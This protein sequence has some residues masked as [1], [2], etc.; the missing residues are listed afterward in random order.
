MFRC[1]M[2]LERGSALARERIGILGGAFDPFHQGHLRMA[3]T[4]MDFCKLDKMYVLPA[5]DDSYKT[6]AVNQE[7]RWKM[8]VTAC[9]QDSRLIPTRMEMDRIPPAYTVDTLLELK[10][11]N[12]RA[13][14]FFVLGT[15]A[16]MKLHR[17]H[18]SEEALPLCTFLVCPRAG[19]V[20]LEAFNAEKTRLTGLG[21]RFSMIRMTP[22]SISSTEIREKL[23]AGE[24]TPNL[25]SPVREYCAL[26]GLYGMPSREENA[27]I[28][29]EKLFQ[30]LTAHRFAHSLSVAN[31]ARRLARIYGIDQRQAEQAGLLH[32]CAKCMPLKKMRRIA[33]EHSLTNDPAVLNSNALMHSLV[34]AWVARNEYDMADPEVLEAIAYHNTGHVGMS[35]LAMCVCLADSIEPTRGSFPLLE[36]VRALSELSLERALLMSLEGTAEYVK[37]RGKYLH[38]RT[39]ETIAWLK[40]LPEVRSQKK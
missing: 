38:P 9:S 34:G 36:Q 14:L 33:I 2:I 6:T 37:S 17:W 40:T 12:P 24:P 10:K 32:D 8:V 13:D 29:L 22:V 25:F 3:V 1:E 26:K 31:Y 7:D 27:E 18:R 4:A 23:S 21:A 35:R 19:E 15:D 28:W 39:Q 16:V 11:K 5:G 30:T 20:L